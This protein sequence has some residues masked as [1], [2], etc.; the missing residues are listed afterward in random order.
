MPRVGSEK[1]LYLRWDHPLCIFLN[2]ETGRCGWRDWRGRAGNR[3]ALVNS[4]LRRHHLY[5]HNTNSKAYWTP[6]SLFPVSYPLTSLCHSKTPP[7]CHI[8]FTPHV[9]LGLSW[10]WRFPQTSDGF[11]A[12]RCERGVLRYFVQYHSIGIRGNTFLLFSLGLWV[13]TRKTETKDHFCHILTRARSSN[14]TAL[15]GLSMIA[16]LGWYCW[17]SPLESYFFV[18]Y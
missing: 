13:F 8:R 1:S 11:W 14:I 7:G 10:L 2:G 6:M 17:D 12:G 5:T 3:L 9:F 4:P 15:L 16:W 18:V